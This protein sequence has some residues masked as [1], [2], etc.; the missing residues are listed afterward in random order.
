[1]VKRAMPNAVMMLVVVFICF[2][3]LVRFM[4]RGEGIA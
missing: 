4:D 2:C 1:V 3:L